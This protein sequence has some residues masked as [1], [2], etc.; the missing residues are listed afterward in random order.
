[1]GHKCLLWVLIHWG[2]VSYEYY[3]MFLRA[4]SLGGLPNSMKYRVILDHDISIVVS[5]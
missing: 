3:G 5:V 2:L 1:M 4:D